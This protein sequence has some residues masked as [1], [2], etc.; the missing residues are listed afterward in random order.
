MKEEN[1]PSDNSNNQNEENVNNVNIN[2]NQSNI[3]E[4]NE[5][6]N[7]NNINKENLNEQNNINNN[8]NIDNNNPNNDNIKEEKNESDEINN[9]LAG[10]DGEKEY[11][12]KLCEINIC[13]SSE[14]INLLNTLKNNIW[15]NLE[16]SYHCSIFKNIKNI[17]DQEISLITFNGTPRQNTSALYQLQKYLLDTK[18]VQTDTNKK[19]N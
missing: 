9:I 15:I 4:N 14:E 5:D 19:D 16:N 12:S 18:N 2:E 1:H 11:D 7:I 10:D 8:I 3:N 13:L 17:D 6:K